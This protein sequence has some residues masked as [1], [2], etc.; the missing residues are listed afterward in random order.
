MIKRLYGK[1]LIWLFG[2]PPSIIAEHC[3]DELRKYK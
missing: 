3:H 2:I 1:F